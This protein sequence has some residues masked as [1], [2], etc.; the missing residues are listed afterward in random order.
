MCVASLLA[1]DLFGLG[2]GYEQR[3]ASESID[4]DDSSMIL[5]PA[6]STATSTKSYSRSSS[7]IVSSLKGM[8]VSE[9]E[10]PVPVR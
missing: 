8:F 4:R 6:S 5:S 10:K 9:R 1:D 3:S 7:S 2:S